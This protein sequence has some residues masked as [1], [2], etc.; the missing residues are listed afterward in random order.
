MARGNNAKIE[1]QKIIADAF[2]ENFI[3]EIDK[4]LYV[5]AD[6]GTEKVQ[7]ALSLTCPKTFVEA[8]TFTPPTRIIDLGGDL[9]FE[10]MS[11]MAKKMENKEPAVVTEEEQQNIADLLARLGL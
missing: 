6:D 7:I 10:A 11:E 3:G 2:G 4:K 5:W 8:T 9:D 1:V